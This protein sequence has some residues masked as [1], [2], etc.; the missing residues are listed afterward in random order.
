MVVMVAW[1]EVIARLP[2]SFDCAVVL[3]VVRV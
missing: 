3:V 2:S 1:N